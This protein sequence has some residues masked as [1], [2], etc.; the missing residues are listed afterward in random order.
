M[1]QHVIKAQILDLVL[2]CVN[3]AIT[4]FEVRLDY[5]RA[6]VAVLAC[7]CVVGACVAALCL[8]VGDIAVLLHRALDELC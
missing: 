2:R 1:L 6:R 5:E 7:A 3:L 4:V 8:D